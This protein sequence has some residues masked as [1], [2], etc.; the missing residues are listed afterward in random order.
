MDCGYKE[1]LPPKLGDENEEQLHD[2]E[3]AISTLEVPIQ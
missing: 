3:S 1:R 2:F